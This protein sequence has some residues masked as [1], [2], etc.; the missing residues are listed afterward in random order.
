MQAGFARIDV[1][2]QLGTILTGYFRARI[3][4]GILDPVE[5]NAVAL[6]AGE[7]TVLIIT[8]DFMSAT[9]QDVTHYRKLISEETGIPEDHVFYQSLHPHTSTTPGTCGPSDHLYQEYLCRKF[10]DVAKMALADMSEA[11]I[12]FGEKE[13]AEPVSFVRR[14]IM[15]DGSV[16]TNPGRL[17]PDVDR[18]LYDADNT[19]RLVK[20]EREAKETIAVVG[21]QTHPDMIGGNQ[22]S[23]DWPGFVRRI[24]EKTFPDTHCILING[25]QGDVNHIN[26]FKPAPTKGIEKN[27]PAFYEAKYEACREL[28]Q[29]I[30]DAV[31]EIWNQ[32]EETAV[33]RIFSRVEMKLIP[34]KTEGLERMAECKEIMARVAAGEKALEGLT[35]G[36]KGD[37]RRI[38]AMDR[39][40]LMQKVP[41]S[42][43][44]FG[45]IAL[46]GY[47]GEPFTEY[48]MK[49]REAFPEL[50]I[51]TA[52]LAN[53]GQGYL[54]SAAAFEE[55]GY[56]AASSNFTPATAP[57]LQG[58]AID[59]LKEYLEK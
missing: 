35:M 57:T 17:N 45:K 49:V 1:T 31:S 38:A 5:L 39:L 37:I 8:G 4:D 15:K 11:R 26:V 21:F 47:G 16:Q 3:S 46:V 56:E 23:A 48:A 34:S 27:T 18:P 10:C 7:D 41:V 51:L 20:L 29:I 33:D 54:P 55:G 25:C 53:G 42:V 22:F 28:A 50:F 58:A 12:S 2:P 43:V 13:T 44:A 32:A 36:E 14:Y 6:S 24:T 40:M 52:C 9:E 19:V 30:V 59:M